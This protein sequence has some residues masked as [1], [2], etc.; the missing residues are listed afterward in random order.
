[1]DLYYCAVDID[2]KEMAQA[3]KSKAEEVYE[4]TESFSSDR[5][6]IL[7]EFAKIIKYT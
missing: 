5:K 1:M 6:F 4:R 2:D 3:A 7:N